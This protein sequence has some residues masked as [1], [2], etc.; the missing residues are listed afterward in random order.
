M[1]RTEKRPLSTRAT[2]LRFD[3]KSASSL[4]ICS[5]F[6]IAAKRSSTSSATS[7]AVAWLTA[8]ECRT[9]FFMRSNVAAF[10]SSP[11]AI[12]AALALPSARDRR[13]CAISRSHFDCASAS[14]CSSLRSADFRFSTCVFWSATCCSKLSFICL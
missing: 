9:L 7:S 5:S 1:G 3:F 6:S 2:R 12:C 8:S 4:S 10:D 11:T 13:C 14:F